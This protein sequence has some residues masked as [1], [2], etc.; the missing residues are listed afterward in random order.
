VTVLAPVELV[1]LELPLDEDE[2]DE[3]PTLLP[4]PRLPPTEP[5]AISPPEM[6]MR[7]VTL[8]LASP[9]SKEAVLPPPR[10]TGFGAAPSNELPGVEGAGAAAFVGTSAST[11]FFTG[12]VVAVWGR[13]AMRMGV[14][15]QV[16][17]FEDVFVHERCQR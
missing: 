3:P 7:N 1:A 6:E 17:Q 5:F 14:L 2:A 10:S 8:R 12:E 13:L 9:N 11:A 16:R 4:V 15:G